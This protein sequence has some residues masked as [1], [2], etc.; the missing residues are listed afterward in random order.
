MLHRPL[1]AT[2][3]FCAIFLFTLPSL[4]QAYEL[5]KVCFDG[6]K[7]AQQPNKDWGQLVDVWS[8]CLSADLK[9]DI[10]AIILNNR[11]IA[12]KNLKDYEGALKDYTRA[13]GLKPDYFYAMNNRGNVLRDMGRLDQAMVDYNQAI[14]LQPAYVYA[15]YNRGICRKA[16]GDFDGAIMDYNKAIELAPGFAAA[17]GNR[18]FAYWAKAQSDARHALDLDPSVTVPES[19]FTE[20]R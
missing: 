4:V 8:E 15:H 10:R 11:G 1:G 18:A 3:L 2:A 12:K 19:L 17:Y 20:T 13:L 9:P 7:L 5:P 14:T 6:E 16:R